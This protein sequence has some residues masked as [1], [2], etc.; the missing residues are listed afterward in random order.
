MGTL[1]GTR[2]RKTLFLTLFLVLFLF[3]WFGG[4][5]PKA[6]DL[7][8]SYVKDGSFGGI[9][10]HLNSNGTF[11]RFDGAREAGHGHWHLTDEK[12]LF[13]TGLEFD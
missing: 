10:Y 6:K 4:C 12:Y 11:K 7:P 5:K 8:G 13:D 1:I 2:F 3:W 9:T